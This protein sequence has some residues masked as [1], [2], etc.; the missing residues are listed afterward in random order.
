[1][2]KSPVQ[3]K[4]KNKDTQSAKNTTLLDFMGA[5][6][7]IFSGKKVTRTEWNDEDEYFYMVGEQLHVHHN[8]GKYHVLAL[9]LVDVTGTDYYVLE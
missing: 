8:D 5:C 3:K 7:A 2:S 6:E 4:N 1:M 9:R